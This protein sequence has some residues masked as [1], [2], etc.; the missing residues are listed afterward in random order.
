MPP[1]N[2]AAIQYGVAASHGREPASP[3]KRVK[4]DWP[5]AL[6][7]IDLDPGPVHLVDGHWF[8]VGIGLAIIV[9]AVVIGLEVDFGPNVGEDGSSVWMILEN[10]FCTVWVVEMSMR[11]YFHRL[12]YFYDGWNLMDFTLVGFSV[13][14][15]WVLVHIEGES[16]KLLASMRSVRLLRLLR[17]VRLV[18]LL[19]FFREL[20]LIVKGLL[21][22]LRT[23]AWVG[24]LLSLVMYISSIFLTIT[25][26]K[27]CETGMFHDWA[28]CD[29]LFGTIPRTMFSLYQLTTLESWAMVIARPIMKEAGH[30][31]AF[32]LV[33]QFLTTWGLLN[34]VVGVIVESTLEAAKSDQD[35]I[36]LRQ[37]QK[38][39]QQLEQL[40]DI[41]QAADADG[42]GDMSLEEFMNIASQQETIRKFQVLELPTDETEE[43]FMILDEQGKGTLSIKTFIENV[44]KL[45]G[46]AKSKDV[47]Q[48]LVNTRSISRRLE[49]VEKEF[50]F[51]ESELLG[52]DVAARS[53]TQ[54]RGDHS[55][56][57][58]AAS[59]DA[60]ARTVPAERASGRTLEPKSPEHNRGG[61][62]GKEAVYDAITSVGPS[63]MEEAFEVLNGCLDS[64][65]SE[66]ARHVLKLVQDNLKELTKPGHDPQRSAVRRELEAL[67]DQFRRTK[68]VYDRG[69]SFGHGLTPNGRV[70]ARTQAAAQGASPFSAGCTSLCQDEV[71]RR[72][73]IP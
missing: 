50:R 3:D 4:N 61:A 72:I 17:L 41:F 55:G 36:V 6:L 19:R 2:V 21:D 7:D 42:S 53:P 14:D 11:L 45:Q 56:R 68:E 52:A 63:A 27:E 8:N 9:N 54:R 43:L 35:K 62:L 24:M 67:F 20:W 59:N 51:A 12:K 10:V 31:L 18:R 49:R 71:S 29:E 64:S 37:K 30:V 48:I 70:P 26:G 57:N 66:G 73:M 69:A 28:A 5:D 33:Y 60:S 58:T 38:R 44:G 40:R 1:R 25:V 22:S 46:G 39:K 23:L 13:A 32:L 15:S 47:M 16:T 34:V 65:C